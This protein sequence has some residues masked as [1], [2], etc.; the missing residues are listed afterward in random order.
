MNC[1]HLTSI[2]NTRY[3]YLTCCLAH[4]RFLVNMLSGWS[5]LW[6]ILCAKGNQSAPPL[7]VCFPFS[8]CFAW[9]MNVPPKAQVLRVGPSQ[10]HCMAIIDPSGH[11][12]YQKKV[13][14]FG[15]VSSKEIIEPGRLLL[16]LTFASW[17]LWGGAEHHPL[18]HTP[19]FTTDP[20]TTES[21]NHASEPPKLYAK[22]T[23]S[24]FKVVVTGKGTIIEE[25]RRHKIYHFHPFEVCRSVVLTW[26]YLHYHLPLL[27]GGGL[28]F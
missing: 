1:I 2:C 7:N 27:V 17:L 22:T 24:S 15:G 8:V 23:L 28:K 6:R 16:S 18:P 19:T 10:G 20:K 26:M 5:L 3:A 13:W 12:S 14:S 25:N 9:E 11:G 21:T 4:S